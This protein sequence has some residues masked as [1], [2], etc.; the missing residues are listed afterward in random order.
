M[1]TVLGFV[2]TNVVAVASFILELQSLHVAILYLSILYKTYLEFNG[3]FLGMLL[4][5]LLSGGHST[6]QIKE[7]KSNYCIHKMTCEV[8][9]FRSKWS[10]LNCYIQNLGRFISGGRL[11]V[12]LATRPTL[13]SLLANFCCYSG[14]HDTQTSFKMDT[15]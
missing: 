14:N 4:S 1:S 6:A 11:I 7:T 9:G 3:I 5:S 12:V 2:V 8:M 15:F 13:K 10:L